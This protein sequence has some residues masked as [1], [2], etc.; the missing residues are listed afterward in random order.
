MSEIQKRNFEA[1]IYLAKIDL[2]KWTLLHDGEHRHG[3]M[4]TNILEALNS[5]LKKTRVL[6]L[7]VLVELIFN[8]LVN[9]FN[10][11][12]QEAQNSVHPF[13]I[14]VFNKFLQ[15]ELKSR[16]HTGTTYNPR[17]GIYMVKYPICL[18]GTDSNVYTLKMNK[19]SCSCGKWQEYTLPCSHALAAYRDNSTRPNAYVPDIYSFETYRR[20]Y[21]SNFYPVGHEDF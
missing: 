19:K 4:A 21:Q 5:V 7:K 6:S 13:P 9:Y 3:M 17:E 10:Q 20:T 8:K 1:Y 2:E 11:H 14:R 16:D 15:I 18:D 12:C